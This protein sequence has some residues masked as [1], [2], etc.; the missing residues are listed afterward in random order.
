MAT[1]NACDTNIPIEV[2]KGGTGVASPTD[3]A[4]LIGSGT[5]AVTP[6]TV[7][8]TGELLVGASGADPAFGT[9]ANGNFTFT[10]GLPGG[11]TITKV[12]CG[13]FHALALLADGSVWSV[14]RNNYGQLGLGDTNNRLTYTP[15]AGIA[16]SGVTDIAA[17]FNHSVI[18]KGGAV[19]ACGRGD[20]GALG[21][22]TATNRN[23]MTAMVSP[24]N[25]GVT[26]IACGGGNH[27]ILS[28][29]GAL[30]GTGANAS[31][32]LGVGDTTQRN[33]PTAMSSPGDSGITFIAC[34]QNHTLALKG[35]VGYA[36]GA[37]G[38][39][40]CADSS[41]TSKNVL[42]AMASPGDSGVTSL[43]GGAQHTVALK[44]DA[45]FA[46]GFN[47]YGQI[48]DGSNTQRTV[49]T[50]ANG[51]GTSGVTSVVAGKYHTLALKSG[52]AYAC[53]YGAY[54]QRGD[55]TLT[56]V[57]TLTA[58]SAPGTSGVDSIYASGDD[59]GQDYTCALKTGALYSC[60][61][62]GY[63]ALATR[64]TSNR[65]ILTQE[66]S[67]VGGARA[68][69]ITH[70][71]NTNAASHAVL[72]VSTGGSN[73]GDASLQFNITANTNWRFGCDN[74]S[75]DRLAIC[76]TVTL[77]TTDCIE[78]ETTGEIT[79]PLQS[80]FMAYLGTTDSNVTGDG[81]NFTVGTGN[82][83]TE[84]FDLNSDF[85]T[86][87]TFTAPITG[88]YVLGL[89]ITVSGM[90]SAN[91]LS[92]T[93]VTSNRTYYMTHFSGF[94]IRDSVNNYLSSTGYVLADMDAS[95]TALFKIQVSGDSGKVSDVIG[96]AS[97]ITYVYG[98][99]AV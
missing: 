6:L 77:G 53:G 7:G 83:L 4:V 49:L 9:S 37:N 34:G 97:P 64:D 66:G 76:P 43:S 92:A 80:A 55:G 91:A 86:N 36:C 70:T 50:A 24:G 10:T 58:L 14:G 52:V 69:N 68:L 75:S 44:T 82:A 72:T 56:N 13:G 96:G 31:G 21:D 78:L 94:A 8:A 45:M 30:Y 2:T 47:L 32:Q 18:L 84:V 51:A 46:S 15:L 74:S 54:G 73:S 67:T 87:G 65:S 99:L 61:Y 81:T 16:S 28:K 40:Q 60:G 23:V 38:N 79:K 5:G 90:D 98:F 63:G 41:T 20:L 33:L 59:T 39:G 85:N 35:D 88:R 17:G 62:N 29:S 89:C 95:D 22:N 42:T 48:G 93:I 27:T 1:K 71:D 3:H 19:Y 57:N 25:S 11:L 26:A 12:A